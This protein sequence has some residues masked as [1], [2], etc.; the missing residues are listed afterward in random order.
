[1]LWSTDW[2][3]WEW[4]QQKIVL[5]WGSRCEL[6]QQIDG[7][8]ASAG[9]VASPYLMSSRLSFPTYLA[10]SVVRGASRERS[11]STSISVISLAN[12]SKPIVVVLWNPRMEY[13]SL[14]YWVNDL[15]LWWRCYGLLDLVKYKK[16]VWSVRIEKGNL[17][18]SWWSVLQSE[19]RINM[20]SNI[21][22]IQNHC[23]SL[24]LWMSSRLSNF[25]SKLMQANSGGT[26]KSSTKTTS[27]EVSCTS[28]IIR[29]L[30]L[31]IARFTHSCHIASS[32]A[33]TFG[34]AVAYPWKIVLLRHSARLW[35]LPHPFLGQV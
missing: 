9:R 22:S 11:P 17:V 4:K 33:G 3:L 34:L 27:L 28:G 29:A 16:A 15:F 31:L 10:I 6:I 25:S 1:V 5:A 35:F 30:T 8:T 20:Y 21:W 19:T 7:S 14:R 12:L 32:A 2:S 26:L 23:N 24:K 13:Q 18:M